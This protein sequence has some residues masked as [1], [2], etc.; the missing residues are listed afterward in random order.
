MFCPKD[1]KCT[2][3]KCTS[4]FLSVISGFPSQRPTCSPST[5]R[6]HTLGFCP[7]FLQ[8]T[9]IHSVISHADL[10]SSMFL[11]FDHLLEW[12]CLDTPAPVPSIL[13]RCTLPPPP[14]S[15]SPLSYN[16]GPSGFPLHLRINPK[17]SSL[18]I[19]P[20]STFLESQYLSSIIFLVV[21]P[22]LTNTREAYILFG[23]Q[24]AK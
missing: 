21:C 4:S 17:I 3:N 22:R 18:L 6:A 16:T 10:P 23:K 1:E 7:C 19:A 8:F 14:P 20:L 9:K 13:C 5:P 12:K 15:L 11:G 2:S 24:D